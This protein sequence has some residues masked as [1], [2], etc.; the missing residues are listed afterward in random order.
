[1][2][3]IFFVVA[4]LALFAFVSAGAMAAEQKA[5]PAKPAPVKMHKFTGA[6]GNID[7]MA[8]TFDVKAKVKVKGKTEEKTMT[9]VADDSTKITKGKKALT[10]ADLKTGMHASVQY[11]VEME[12]NMA[13]TVKVATPKVAAKP[14]GK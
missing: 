8:K 11:K 7:A 5:A 3:K 4:A 6:I 2:K 12:K 1:M 9:F 13:A 14:K 10:F